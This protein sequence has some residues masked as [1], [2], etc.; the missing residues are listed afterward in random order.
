MKS[1]CNLVLTT[2]PQR[3]GDHFRGDKGVMM[4]KVSYYK[5]CHLSW[6]ILK[7]YEE[8]STA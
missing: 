7:D 3:R 8:L 2:R 6:N 1:D 4:E 5:K